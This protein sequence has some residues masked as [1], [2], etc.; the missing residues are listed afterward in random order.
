[1][2]R[3]RGEVGAQAPAD[4]PDVL[5]VAD[6]ILFDRAGLVASIGDL[7]ARGR[8]APWVDPAG[9]WV[10]TYAQPIV[11]IYNAIYRRPPR[12]WLELADETWRSR[13]V[14]E[15]PE[16]ML[17]TGPAFAELQAALGPEAW[18]G[19]LAELAASGIRQVA[20]NERAVLEVATGARWAGLSNLNV[21]RRVRPDRP[22][23]T[24]SWTRPRA[25]RR[26]P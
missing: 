18:R 25:S 13:L 3:L 23:A 20:D 9:R 2:A 6:P 21:A 12:S 11:A 15:A 17:T 24:S 8:P 10:S 1:M 19:W 5:F 26:S 7:D 4:R 14:V 22:S 16:R